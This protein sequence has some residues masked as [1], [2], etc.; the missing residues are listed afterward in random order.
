MTTETNSTEPALKLTGFRRLPQ[1]EWTEEE[2]ACLRESRQNRSYY[3][4]HRS[5]ILEAHWDRHILVIRGG[6][7]RSFETRGEMFEFYDALDPPTRNATFLVP[8]RRLGSSYGYLR[9]RQ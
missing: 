4:E 5:E 6:E 7:V 1:R 2:R 9:R 8:R 3:D